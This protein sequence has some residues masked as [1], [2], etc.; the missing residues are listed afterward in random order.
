MT[1][2]IGIFDSGLG[3]LTVYKKLKNRFPHFSFAYLAD[4]ERNPYGIKTDDEIKKICSS[5]L[6]FFLEL[7]VKSV[8]IACHTASV[9]AF[10]QLKTLYSIPIT[11]MHHATAQMLLKLPFGSTVLILGTQS[12]VKNGFYAKVLDEYRKDIGVKSI[13]CPLLVEYIQ[14]QIHDEDML[15]SI[16]DFYGIPNFRCDYILLACTHFPFIKT[17]LRKKIS[18]LTQIIDPAESIMLNLELSSKSEHPVLKEDH[19]FVHGSV[20]EFNQFTNSALN[21]PIK[22]SRVDLKSMPT[23]SIDAANP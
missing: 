16:L 9:V 4:S 10:D 2:D 21:F 8:V 7:K 20:E 13:A 18:S 17:H 19:F 22:S 14:N 3:G 5:N 11:P 1:Y 12:T 6:D 15:G 23:F